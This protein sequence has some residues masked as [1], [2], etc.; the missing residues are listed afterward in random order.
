MDD[1]KSRSDLVM[2]A[3]AAYVPRQL[4]SRRA[5]RTGRDVSP[6]ALETVLADI[7]EEVTAGA[8]ERPRREAKQAALTAW[9]PRAIDD[10]EHTR[11]ATTPTRGATSSAAITEGSNAG[12]RPR[13]PPG[14]GKSD[15]VGEREMQPGTVHDRPENL[16]SDAEDLGGEA[17]EA[18]AKYG[19]IRV[20]VDNFYY[21]AFRYTN[22]DDAIA[23][24]KRHPRAS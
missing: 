9:S 13:L 8:I 3:K 12:P 18:M 15:N 16:R 11:Q 4:A 5:G 2:E 22:L 1:D 7:S 24:A 10:L 23:E 19:I 17:G 20:R 14:R 6:Q 21:G